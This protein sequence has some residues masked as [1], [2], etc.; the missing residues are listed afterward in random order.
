MIGLAALLVFLGSTL[1]PAAWAGGSDEGGY[2]LLG[3]ELTGGKGLPEDFL[4]PAE[5]ESGQRLNAI[6]AGQ[7]EPRPFTF[8][9]GGAREW[10]LA[11]RIFLALDGR[12]FFQSRLGT[13]VPRTTFQDGL[14]NYG[15]AQLFINLNYRFST[16]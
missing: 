5:S 13:D 2:R 10:P 8:Y 14:P 12:F 16:D 9:L 15:S 4:R 7:R 6:V 11:E 1:V 3:L